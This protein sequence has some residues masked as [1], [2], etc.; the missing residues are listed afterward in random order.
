LLF[1]CRRWYTEG[2]ASAKA[3]LM[4]VLGEN[5]TLKNQNV[6]MCMKKPLTL[7][8]EAKERTK[9]E[10]DKLEPKKKV[11]TPTQLLALEPI[12][13]IWSGRQDLNLRPHAP[14][15]RALAN[16]ATPRI[17]KLEWLALP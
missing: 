17:I 5:P 13:S 4:F 7:I 11:Y 2:D 15:A 14:H 6:L 10:I 9:L 3:K 12:S 1:N 16:C 8:A